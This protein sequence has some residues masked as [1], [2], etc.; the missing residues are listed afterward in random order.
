M[1]VEAADVALAAEGSVEAHQQRQQEDEDRDVRP[2]DLPD[3]QGDPHGTQGPAG[4]VIDPAEGDRRGHAGAEDLGGVGKPNRAGIHK[5]QLLIGMCAIRMMSIA[6][7][8]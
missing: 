4:S 3:T 5:A 6:T 1:E 2:I 8:R 7:P